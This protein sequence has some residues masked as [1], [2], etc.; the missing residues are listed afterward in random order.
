MR[1]ESELEEKLKNIRLMVM[2]VDGTMT[3]GDIYID[4]QETETKQFNIKDGCGIT[5]GHTAGLEFMILTGR[6]SAC[7]QK[8]AR[9]LRIRRVYQNVNNKA[10]FLKGYLEREQ[11]SADTVAYIGDDINDLYA[12]QMAGVAFCPSDAAEEI[13][14]ISHVVLNHRGG[15]GAVREAVERILKSAGKWEEAIKLAFGPEGS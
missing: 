4:S 3:R 8:R 9:E 11:I 7:L 10:D 14:Q 1:N 5:A 15:D 13:R 6:E 12:M 2:D